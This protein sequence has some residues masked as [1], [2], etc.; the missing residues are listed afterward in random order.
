M[1]HS[2]LY[3]SVFSPPFFL[4]SSSVLGLGKEGISFDVCSVSYLCCFY[5]CWAD[6]PCRQPVQPGRIAVEPNNFVLAAGCSTVSC[7]PPVL[8]W[9]VRCSVCMDQLRTLVNSIW[10]QNPALDFPVK[11]CQINVLLYVCSQQGDIRPGLFTKLL[12]QGFFTKLLDQDLFTKLLDQDLFTKLL[13]QGL[14]TKL[15]D[16]GLFTKLCRLFLWPEI[17]CMSTHVCV[18][19]IHVWMICG[20]TLSYVLQKSFQLYKR[21]YYY[22]YY[23][24]AK[25]IA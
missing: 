16:Q 8:L 23:W 24:S 13:D 5:V 1:F 22:Y 14:F 17:M 2:I 11:D 9:S 15:L 21:S 18:C 12:D 6:M 10:I 4:F 7:V 20:N 25:D 3:C 19:Y